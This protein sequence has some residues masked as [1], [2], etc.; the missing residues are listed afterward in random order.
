[1]VF[2]ASEQSYANAIVDRIDPEGK[3][4]DYRMYRQHCI[5]TNFH[6]GGSTYLKDL[7]IIANRDLKDIILVDNATL[8]FAL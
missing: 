3:F 7:R 4:F 8:C 6:L 2:T 5:E 1:V